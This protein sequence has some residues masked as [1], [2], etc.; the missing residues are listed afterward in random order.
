[1]EEISILQARRADAIEKTRANCSELVASLRGK[2][3]KRKQDVKFANEEIAVAQ[4]SV[5]RLQDSGDGNGIIDALSNIT[6][7]QQDIQGAEKDI[8]DNVA[9]LQAK[10]QEISEL[11]V[12]WE[13]N[14]E[15]RVSRLNPQMSKVAENLWD[16]SELSGLVS[17]DIMAEEDEE[18]EMEA[19]Q[20]GSPSLDM[21]PRRKRGR[22]DTES[23][24]PS[25]SDESYRPRLESNSFSPSPSAEDSVS[26]SLSTF[27]GIS[28]RLSVTL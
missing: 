2:I 16:E 12:E 20:A 10:L 6:R 1:M 7:L 21:S 13:M 19:G 4:S 27:C 8:Q 24:S 26:S 17:D 15:R 22:D 9:L 28:I 3:A 14:F 11:E 5:I 23:P 18:V 25:D